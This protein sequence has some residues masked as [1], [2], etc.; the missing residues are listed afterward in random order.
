MA[1]YRAIKGLHIQS[2][3]SDN[4]VTQAG[5]IWYN[6]TTGKLRVVKA[7]GAWA[8]G[9]NLNSGRRSLNSCGTQ[10][11]GL[12][13][14]GYITATSALSEEY[15]GSAWTEGNDLNT[16]RHY[17]GMTGTQTA[18]LVSGGQGAVPPPDNLN[19]LLLSNLFHCKF[20]SFLKLLVH[21]HL[22]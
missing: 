15:N 6:S 18:G 10:T 13:A 12:T 9:G 22:Q 21:V 3:S 4:A 8:S 16:A 7:V 2:V 14:G 1:N 17:S 19:L 20:Q 11:A 5:D